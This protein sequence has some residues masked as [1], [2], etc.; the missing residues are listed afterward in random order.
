MRF[1]AL[2]LTVLLAG[3]QAHFLQYEAPSQLNQVNVFA[4]QLKHFTHKVLTHFD[5]TEFED[6]KE[7]LGQS[8]DSLHGYFQARFELI[9][10]LVNVVLENNAPMLKKWTKD[11]EDLRK[12]L[13][14]KR[15]ELRQVLEKH[16]EEYRDE[17]K[18]FHEEYLVMQHRHNEELRSNLDPM[19]KSVKE[20]IGI[21][22]EE[23]KS[24]LM[25]IVKPLHEKLTQ[26]VKINLK[27][28]MEYKDRMEGLVLEFRQRAR[29][30]RLW[31]MLNDLNERLNYRFKAIFEAFLDFFRI[32]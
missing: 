22:W 20:K 1:V 26:E 28:Y 5:N 23:T 2:A 14:P 17:L 11:I 10:L 30:G 6:Y 27:R 19:V 12:D 29:S 16:F 3:C 4:D 32:E 7:F 18:L 13:E 24:K 31:K 9:T 8:V 25:P 21:I 15:E